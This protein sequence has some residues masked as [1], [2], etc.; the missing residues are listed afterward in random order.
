M[1]LVSS[2]SIC[3]QTGFGLLGSTPILSLNTT[4]FHGKDIAGKPLFQIGSKPD[5]AGRPLPG[6]AVQ[7]VDPS[8]WNNV[9][10]ANEVG[11]ILI[12]GAQIS[13]AFTTKSVES[14]NGWLNTKLTGY[15]DEKGFVNLT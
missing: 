2:R 6:I 12:K 3:I 13:N 11:T 15:L 14:F 4:D 7:I 1:K 9:L 5:S 10:K 8:N